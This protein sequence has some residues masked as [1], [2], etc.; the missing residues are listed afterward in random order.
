GDN[1][2]KVVIEGCVRATELNKNVLITLVGKQDVIKEQ[3]SKCYNGSN[4]EILN[5]NDVISNEDHPVEAI[6]TKKDSSMVKGLETL[7]KDNNYCAFVSAGNSG[8]LLTGAFMIVKRIKGVSRPAMCP[9][10]PTVT[11]GTVLLVDCGANADCKPENL[12]HFALM[13]DAYSKVVLNKT[14]VKIALLS[15]GTEEGKGNELTKASYDMLKQLNINFVGNIEAR[16][17]LDGGVD[18]VVTDGY[19]GN[20]ALK[21]A[22]GMA[23]SIFTLLNQNIHEGGLRAKLGAL[24]LKPSLRKVKHTLDYN[25]NGGA[26]FVGVE[27][28]VMKVHGS[29][30]GESI[31]KTILKANEM[32]EKNIIEKIKLAVDSNSLKVASDK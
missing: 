30:S 2:P 9:E 17:I 4:I 28:I 7:A 19:T 5:A 23:K 16:E 21:A 25:Q 3:L 29:A 12:C 1:A 24:L 26:C 11:G 13:A 15:N 18:V 27:K 22:E 10:V 32:A 14:D 31:A 8:A 6:R 20:I